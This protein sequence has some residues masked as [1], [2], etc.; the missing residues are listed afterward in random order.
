[1][2]QTFGFVAIT[3]ALTVLALVEGCEDDVDVN[4]DAGADGGTCGAPLAS[5]SVGPSCTNVPA[6]PTPTCTALDTDYSPGA[7]DM[8]DACISDDGTYHRI[9]ESISSIARVIAFED[10]RALLFD[11]SGD[12]SSADFL[13][14]RLIYQEDEGLDSRVVRRYDP[15]FDM[16]ASPVDCTMDGVPAAKPDYCLGPAILQP[17]LLDAFQKGALGGCDALPRVHA[18]RIEAALLWFLYASQNKESWTCTTTAK[19]CDSSYAYYAGG[20]AARGG[21]G[22][23]AYVEAADSAAHDRVWDGILALRCWRDLDQAVPAENVTLRD[24][25][26]SQMDRAVTDGLAAVVRDALVEMCSLS[27]AQL[28]YQWAFIATLAP[29]LEFEMRE[30]APG[31]AV[32]LMA[33]VAKTNPAT[34]DVAAAV[35]AIDGVFEC[36]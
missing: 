26:R 36:P 33:E 31:N 19:D 10:I 8:W 11:R 4:P 3:S 1:M 16:S 9:Q 24:R 18:A 35:S 34:V 7:A 29:A 27:G 12:P 15:R 25:A 2:R 5:T 28:D 30:V 17:I 13:N 20:E 21:I 22:L 14:A 23:A 6:K 32:L